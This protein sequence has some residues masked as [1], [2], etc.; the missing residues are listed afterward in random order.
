MVYI[1]ETCL[2]KRGGYGVNVLDNG[3]FQR[4]QSG[5]RAASTRQEVIVNNI[6]N[7]D[8]PYFKR[9]E[10]SFETLLKQQMSGASNELTGI[11]TD[12]RHFVIGPTNNIPDLKITKDETT[13]MNN[14]QNN[15]DVDQEMA[16]LAEN[17]LRYNAYVTQINHQISMKKAAIGGQ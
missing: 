9:S 10:V 8:T 3:N 6:A 1:V 13:S 14:N 16:L 2:K 12:E 17:Q 5:L 11:R 4:L 15:V 7:V